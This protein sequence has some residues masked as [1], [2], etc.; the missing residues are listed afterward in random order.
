MKF[1]NTFFVSPPTYLHSVF[2]YILHKH[3]NLFSVGVVKKYSF[4]SERILINHVIVSVCPA[5]FDVWHF[6]L[7]KYIS[8]SLYLGS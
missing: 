7:N 3:P 8:I 5:E 4:D 6:E 1:K 2:I